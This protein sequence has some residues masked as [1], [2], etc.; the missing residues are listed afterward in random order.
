[1]DAI[2]AKDDSNYDFLEEEIPGFE[3]G[4]P[5]RQIIVVYDKRDQSYKGFISLG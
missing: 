3:E 4:D 1:L 2:I 5:L